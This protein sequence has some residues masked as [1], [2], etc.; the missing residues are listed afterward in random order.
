MDINKIYKLTPQMKIYNQIGYDW[1]PF[2][3]NIQK[4]KF[5]SKIV[6]TDN[7]GL[8]FN[9]QK[10]TN[11]IFD[12]Y[13]PAKKKFGAIV[14]AS[15]VFGIGSSK[16]NFTI[17]SLLSE[18]TEYNY[19]NIGARAYC[20]FQEI[21]LFNSLL[22]SL[23]KIDE[24]IIFSGINDIFMDKYI[25]EYDKILGPMFYTNEFNEKMST[26]S[27]S[28]KRH[29][30]NSF[31]NFFFK[32]KPDIKNLTND[33]NQNIFEVIERNLRCWANI[34]YGM[35]IK[36]SYFLQPMANWCRR[37]LSDEENIIFNELDK[38]SLITNNCLRSINLEIYYEYKNFLIETCKKL[39]INFFDCNE[40]LSDKEF[41][42][43]WLFVDRV[44]LTDL[45]NK[46][47][48]QFIK[49]KI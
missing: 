6:N 49:S 41:N 33:L 32:S 45:G 39:N 34:K 25:N 5:R 7:F 18:N 44:H 11:S 47:M 40:Y 27:L 20:G 1:K 43:K 17:S 9:N 4:S 3:M 16:D 48:C 35:K 10:I 19:F 8:R 29:L 2:I 12:D 24:V 28:L 46:I 22:N 38:G 23:K 15:S 37:E 42:K 36:L 26:V 21:I 14:G 30:I 13:D 31:S